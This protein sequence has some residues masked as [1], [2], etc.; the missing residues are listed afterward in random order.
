[1]RE[2]Q[3]NMPRSQPDHSSVTGGPRNRHER[4]KAEAEKRKAMKLGRYD[5]PASR[6]RKQRNPNSLRAI[7]D[8]HGMPL[9]TLKSRVHLLRKDGHT[10]EDAIRIAVET[11]IGPRGRPRKDE[12]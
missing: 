11:P 3:R 6:K 7:A 2:V 12:T 9:G 1:M 4:R 8:R 10:R 5:W